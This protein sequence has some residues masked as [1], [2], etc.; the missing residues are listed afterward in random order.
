MLKKAVITLLLVTMMFTLLSGCSSNK[1]EPAASK[2]PAAPKAWEPEGRLELV[3][4]Y[5]PGGG[6]DTMLRAM[7]K[8][9]TGQKIITNPINVINK[10]GGNA[11]VG[12]SYIM[13][14]EGSDNHVM[15]VTLTLLTAPM[16][17]PELG[18]THKD[19]TPIARMGVESAVLFVRKGLGINNLQ[20][21]INY[22]KPLTWGG[23]STG[24]TEHITFHNVSKKMGLDAEYVPF[25]GDGETLTAV[26]G[27]H[28][29]IVALNLNGVKD[30]I[31]K[32]DLIPLACAGP[33]RLPQM[34]EL[35]TLKE[36]GVDF[37]ITMY[38]GI[39]GPPN[40]SKE[41]QAWWEEKCRILSETPEWKTN[42][43]DVSGVDP[44]FMNGAEFE[45]YLDSLRKLYETTLKEL[46][47]YKES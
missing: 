36:Q 11:T 15:A 17:M 44:G 9:W 1:T 43:L 27:G 34:P 7:Q 40:M 3:A 25:G 24:A 21:L 26:L 22:K 31:N 32:G 47:I 12:M 14:K 23:T 19:L 16:S 18:F 4:C 37:E 20:D 45:A 8:I 10:P 29:D 46:G 41:A 28:V 38:R 42:Y 13:G 39:Y 5:G 30:Y 35:K 33:E 2:E 6:H